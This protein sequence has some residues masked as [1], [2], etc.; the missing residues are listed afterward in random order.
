MYLFFGF[1][2]IKR[3][4]SSFQVLLNNLMGKYLGN[5]SLF[6]IFALLFCNHKPV[7]YIIQSQS[8]I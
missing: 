6:G 2:W 3:K 8:L 7:H 5:K 1:F 4:N